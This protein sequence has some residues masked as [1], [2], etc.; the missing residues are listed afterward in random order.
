[1]IDLVAAKRIW[2][3]ENA[4]SDNIFGSFM[5]SCYMQ[6]HRSY[7][8]E[9]VERGEGKKGVEGRP[10]RVRLNLG[11]ASGAARIL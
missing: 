3:L 4:S 5:W 9:A 11:L 7:N 10:W 6:H 2:A 1:M 8:E